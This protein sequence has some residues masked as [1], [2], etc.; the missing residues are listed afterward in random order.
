E[1]AI[2]IVRS[3]GGAPSRLADLPL[4][5]SYPS[6]DGKQILYIKSEQIYRARFTGLPPATPMD[7]GDVPFIKALGVQSAPRWSPDGSK[8]AFV[9]TRT[10]H[11]FIGLY[12]VKSR[13]VS[14]PFPGV[15]R[16]LAPT[17]SP[18][19]KRLAFVRRP[20][21][22]FGVAVAQPGRGFF[23]SSTPTSGAVGGQ[24]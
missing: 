14:F 18:D 4:P 3:S 1:R 10:H 9:S 20:G 22:P 7:K 17:W 11:S 2:W 13:T 15:D 12:D 24:L 6:P 16:D 8:I 5:Q 23:V 21:T 19:G